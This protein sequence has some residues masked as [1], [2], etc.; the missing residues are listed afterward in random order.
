MDMPQIAVEYFA[1]GGGLDLE[2]PRITLPSGR[3]RVASNY[4]PVVTGSPRVLGGY[5][6]I[7]GYERYDGRPR[8]S[9]QAYQLLFCAAGFPAV[10]V[11]E[12][13][14][15]QTSGATGKVIEY[16]AGGDYVAV[17]RV[18]GA[19]SDGEDVELLS[20]PGVSIGEID[21]E[22]TIDITSLDD[23]RLTA[24][25]ENEYRA[26]IAAVPGSGPVRGI[27]EYKGMLY[28]WRDNALATA[29]VLHV[30]S[31]SG[32]TPVSLGWTLN[33]HLGGN[34]AIP[35]GATINDGAGTTAV[36]R[37]V[38]V[39]SG[40]WSTNDAAGYLVLSSL[41]G[42]SWTTGEHINIG[43]TKYAT[44]SGGST[45]ITM[46]PG[47][48]VE[49]AIANFTGT[50]S[51]ECMYWVDGVNT[52]FEFD[53]TT[54]SPIRTGM[55]ADTPLHVFSHKNRLF[56]SFS[57]SVQHSAAGNPFSWSVVL[58][59]NE[60][61]VG[62]TVTG[63]LSLPGTQ[64]GGALA[65]FC[66]D[67]T[68]ILYGSSTSDW[69]LVRFSDAVGAASYSMQTLAGRQFFMDEI[70]LTTMGQVQDY[71]NFGIGTLTDRMRAIVRGRSPLVS[72]SAVDRGNGIYYLW[73]TDGQGLAVGVG[74]GGVEG[75][76]PVA[77]A[78]T[79]V[80]AHHTDRNGGEVFYGDADGF[81]YQAD[82]GRSF[83]GEPVEAF[84]SLAFNHSK[85]PTTRKRYRKAFLEMAA[86]SYASVQVSAQLD[87]D[88]PN[89]PQVPSSDAALPGAAAYWDVASWDAFY[90]DS[91]A[92]TKPELSLGGYGQNISLSFYSSSDQELPHT[93]Q[94]AT[95]HYN[96]TRL[97]R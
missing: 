79:P 35:V 54:V 88:D 89:V 14:V 9:R 45:A 41:S 65:I 40:A 70:G 46:L 85:A 84:L 69:N 29:K 44:A 23:N 8:P 72:C 73:F 25:T 57:G 71:G 16:G 77:M 42:G 31:G 95:M 27:C 20:A 13:V 55:T 62:D 5:R 39:Q 76:M 48:V 74:P 60:I 7:G 15:G 59:A 68:H 91:Q 90:W 97:A 43:A 83:D 56:L 38:V 4:I 30:E 2:T 34:T 10:T 87:Y 94:G 17:T 33:F 96:A 18:T 28:A 1:A 92:T 75:V 50:A 58:G 51:A 6:R 22:P 67:S 82:C 66:A 19:F 12:T 21:L 24:L 63:F 81:V 3:A 47:G 49:A 64:A 52:A 53:G 37:K 80:C 11:G 93:I 78:I 86:D 36:V 61:G 32:W 26:S